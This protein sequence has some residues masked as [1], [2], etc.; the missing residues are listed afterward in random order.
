L[1]IPEV[2]I[3]TSRIDHAELRLVAGRS[4]TFGC[5]VA[6]RAHSAFGFLAVLTLATWPSAG[7]AQTTLPEGAPVTV[8]RASVVPLTPGSDY[9][10][11]V[12][13]QEKVDIRARIAGTLIEKRFGDGQAVAKGD[14]LF[15]IDPAPFQAAVDQQKA[16]VASAEAALALARTQFARS[17]ELKRSGNVAQ[18]TLDV[19]RAQADQASA[20]VAAARAAL[21]QA[22]INLSYTTISAPISGRIGKAAL[23]VGNLVGPDAGV[24]ATIVQ[25][26]P[27]QVEFNIS[28]REFLDRR[29]QS[30]VTLADVV[31]RLRF[32]NGTAYGPAGSIDYVDV[33]ADPTVD[34]IKLRAVFPNTDRL[35]FDGTTVRVRLETKDSA[36]ALVVSQAAVQVDQQGAFVLVV[37]GGSRAQV[38]RV[39]MSP[40]PNGLAVIAGGLSEGD[41]VIV[42]GQQR[43]RPGGPVTA[44]QAPDPVPPGADAQ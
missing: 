29:Q 43:V 41:L 37:D 30:G 8:Q 21:R 38:R 18:A 25:Q 40:G 36:P 42:Q 10:G 44:K 4:C 19:N 16:S 28:S 34:S 5:F 32:A 17:S 35:L 33:L 22:E 3:A 23:T 13:A 1:E 11:R 2:R 14:V 12:R 6:R 26:D 31:A 15:L 39:T 7:N 20:N 27:M 9:I 24:L